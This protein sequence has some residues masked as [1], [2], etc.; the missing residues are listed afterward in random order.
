[1]SSRTARGT[2][3]PCLNLSPPQIKININKDR[4]RG[5]EER[6]GGEKSF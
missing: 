4:G 3:K 5:G 6:R 1:V 2:E